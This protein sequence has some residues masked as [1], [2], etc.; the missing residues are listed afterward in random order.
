M[1]RRGPSHLG[2]YGLACTS[3]FKAKCKC[4][5]RTDGEGCQRCHRLRKQ[6]RPSDSLRKR[7]IEKTQSSA[8][9]IRE[10]ECKLDT[11]ISQLQTRNV[12]GGD[13]Q[14]PSQSDS[15]PVGSGADSNHHFHTSEHEAGDSG[16]AEDGDGESDGYH[17][18]IRPAR[19][20]ASPRAVSTS[21]SPEVQL[22]EAE[23]ETLLNTFRS[24]MLSYFPFVHLPADLGAYKLRRDWPF[25]FRAIA[26]A[27]SP[28]SRDK[29][30][31]GIGLKRAI[32]KAILGCDSESRT[33]R[34]DLLL[35]LL[36]Y[37]SW[38]WDH[39]LN[40]GNLPQLMSQAN[41]LACEI[42]MDEPP[43]PD[44]QVRAI[45]TTGFGSGEGGA[46]TRE[47]FLARQRAV[48]ACFALS[49]VVSAHYRQAIDA[50][51]WTPQMEDGLAAISNDGSC[52]TDATLAIQVRLQLL[53]QKSVQVHQHQ[54]L[55]RG[56]VPVTELTNFQAI[57]ALTT[58][59]T[60]RQ[61]IQT[62]LSPA[63]P[64][65]DVLL[66]HI[67]STELSISEV[68]HAVSAM[69]PLMITQ[70]SRLAGTRDLSDGTTPDNN[71]TTASARHE[72]VAYLWQCVRAV[73]AC[74]AALLAPAPSAFRGISFL[75][76]AQLAHCA[77]ALHRL[78][79][80]CDDPA[81]DLDAA[82]EVVKLSRLLNCAAT[83]LELVAVE[84]GE[85]GP[86][87]LFTRLARAMRELGAE[88][89]GAG[90]AEDSGRLLSRLY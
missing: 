43:P 36:T 1:E 85:K 8:S 77:V 79:V 65:R 71:A 70:F 83:K 73:Q 19:R 6:C 2:P 27:A 16:H 56:Q 40:R 47:D 64:Q 87:E 80:V 50:L 54:Q 42:R 66:T 63:I 88:E 4:V 15:R 59:Q 86:D 34:L 29:A 69:V 32:S 82:R 24:C 13:Q 81:W 72:R 14:P 31:R 41:L 18:N 5:A 67:H 39:V 21:D 12:I 37:I 90:G 10:L 74:A 9:R 45:F 76:W 17:A 49:S 35:A 38:G 55:E 26:C 60:Q 48:L 33:G 51:R 57:M 22:S 20:G 58:L 62:S 44:A 61:E 53:T 68:T 46:V 3:C 30:A 89:A 78:T 7:T 52:P 28:L 75:Q 11:L 25:L 84:Q 23:A